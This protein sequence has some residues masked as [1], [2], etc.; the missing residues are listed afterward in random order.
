MEGITHPEISP[1][2]AGT[3]LRAWVPDSRCGCG[4]CGADAHGDDEDELAAKLAG[5]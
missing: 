2:P 5:G 3:A 1:G 4:F